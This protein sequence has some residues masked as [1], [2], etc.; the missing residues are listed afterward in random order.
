MPTHPY[1]ERQQIEDRLIQLNQVIAN[2]AEQVPTDAGPVRYDLGNAR[3]ERAR[4]E[5]RL[6]ALDSV[7][8][9]TRMIAV[10]PMRT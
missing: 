6:E 1:I 7:R 5:R 2:S 9:R 10:W 8:H 4:L 3:Q